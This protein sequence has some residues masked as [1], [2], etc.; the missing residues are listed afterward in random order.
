[1]SQA[2]VGAQ[3]GFGYIAEKGHLP[4]YRSGATTRPFEIVAVADICEARRARAQQLLP[5]ARVYADAIAL[6]AAEA[7]RLDF[8]DIATPPCDH[9]ALAH[10]AID[11]GLHVLCEKPLAASAKDAA[12]MLEH[13]TH[14]KRV[15]FPSHNY[16]HAPVIREVR[17]QLNEGHIGQVR[18]VTLETFRTTHA[19]GVA[20]WQP[21]WRRS[22]R[23]AGGGI[24]MDHGS[25]TFYLAFDWLGTYPTAITAKMSHQNDVD[26]EDHFS[27]TVTFPTGIAVAQLTWNAGVRKVIYTLHGERGA[28]R[29][30]DDELELSV[31]ATSTAPPRSERTRVA[32]RWMDASHSSWF[33]SLFDDFANAIDKGDHAGKEAREALICIELIETAYRSARSGCHELPLAD[34]QNAFASAS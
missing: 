34:F 18:L 16:K 3:I 13:A 28:I 2:L 11:H 20:E 6:L 7:H 21:D 12:A 26:T 1:M 8:V 30:E 4:A 22:R 5:N 10:A 33:V 25:H 31:L 19:K 32:S 15:V 24:A 29:V 9:A 17:K 14:R 27:C 23:F